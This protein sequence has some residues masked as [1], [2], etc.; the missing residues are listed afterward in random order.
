[1]QALGL[2][3]SDDFLG[4]DEYSEICSKISQDL[5]DKL[6]IEEPREKSS[7]DFDGESENEED[8]YDQER[9]G[10]EEEEDFTFVC[11]NPHG[12]PIRPIFPIF[13]RG[14]I[15]DDGE[16][17]DWKLG[18]D[19]FSSLLRPPLR[20]LFIEERE[21]TSSSSAAAESESDELEALPEGTYYELSGKAAMEICKKSNSTGHSKLWKLRE[22][23]HRSHSDGKDAFV[24]LNPSAATTTTSK[25]GRSSKS[26]GDNKVKEKME[27]TSSAESSKILLKKVG[28]KGLKTETT[29][30]SHEK[31]Y[32]KNRTKKEGDKRRSYLPYRQ[33]L[34]G[35]FT[36]VNG[37]SKNVHP[38]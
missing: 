30:S 13:G 21:I 27:S 38:F 8:D 29:S 25:P 1:M 24:F 20:K 32:V 9:G 35:F 4:I 18:D 22:L 2:K 23:V 17:G 6:K 28:A 12:S 3:H 15:F 33:N 14:I 10:N 16:D 34:V 19:S 26:D 37:L 5:K 31:H 36:N 11:T 7:S